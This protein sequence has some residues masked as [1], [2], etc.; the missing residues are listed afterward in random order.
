MNLRTFVALAVCSLVRSEVEVQDGT[1]KLLGLV[2][3]EEYDHLHS[4]TYEKHEYPY[5]N[6]YMMEKHFERFAMFE[7]PPDHL[8]EEFKNDSIVDKWETQMDCL[9]NS[10]LCNETY[11]PQPVIGILTQPVSEGKKS[12]F[13]YTDY[14]LEI[15]DNFVRWGGS[16]TV[17]IPYNITEERLLPLLQQINGVLFTGGGLELVNTTTGEKHPYLQTADKIFKY[18][19]YMKDHKNETFPLMGICQGL[20]VFAIILNDYKLD[21]LDH[22]HIYGENRPVEWEMNHFN[23]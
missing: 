8:I 12:K 23:S 20:Q 10:S 5:R 1:D 7:R 21:V 14:I 22:I 11:D 15:N 19:K 6:I 4:S 3:N 18:S 13:N 2:L 17:A 9:S 16:R